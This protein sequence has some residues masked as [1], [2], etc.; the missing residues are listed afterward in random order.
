MPP[1]CGAPS[2]APWTSLVPTIEIVTVSVMLAETTS[3][4]RVEV[5]AARLA[6]S[7]RLKFRR[8]GLTLCITIRCIALL[9]I[10]YFF[11]PPNLLLDGM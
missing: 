2:S 6:S 5:Q 9:A 11:A 3:G 4:A 8:Q 10:Q 1:I 7:D